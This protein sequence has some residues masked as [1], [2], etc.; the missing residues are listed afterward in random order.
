MDALNETVDYV[1]NE[2][3]PDYDFDAEV[4]PF[5]QKGEENGTYTEVDGFDFE[6]ESTSHSTSTPS[7]NGE[8]PKISKEEEEDMTWN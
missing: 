7:S 2:L 5:L 3:M 4:L 8:A 1:R 6:T